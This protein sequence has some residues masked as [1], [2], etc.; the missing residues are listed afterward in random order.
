[1]TVSFG[2]DPSPTIDYMTEAGLLDIIFQELQLAVSLRSLPV[3]TL[4]ATSKNLEQRL[5]KIYS[6]GT[7]G[8]ITDSAKQTKREVFALVQKW[9]EWADANDVEQNDGFIHSIMLNDY[10]VEVIM[11]MHYGVPQNSGAALNASLDYLQEAGYLTRGTDMQ[12]TPRGRSYIDMQLRKS[13]QKQFTLWAK[14]TFGVQEVANKRER[15]Y[16]FA[17]EFYEL[18][19]ACD[20]DRSE[21]ARLE[22]YTY[23]RE[24]GTIEQEV[25]GVTSTYFV[26]L[27]SLGVDGDKVAGNTLQEIW[28]RQD[29]IREKQKTKIQGSSL[30]GETPT[31][32]T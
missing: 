2:H 19:Q 23:S 13:L 5:R 29:I 27:S 4:N 6:F 24:K 3:T 7:A 12:L 17:E 18:M 31:E 30:P 28:T 10:E 25:G 11:R 1:M 15:L 8:L 26:A 9:K 21:L 14:I 16:R 22:E 32:G 20:I